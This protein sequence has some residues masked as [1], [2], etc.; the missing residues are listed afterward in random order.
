MPHG[1]PSF[2]PE[3]TFYRR[4]WDEKSNAPALPVIPSKIVDGIV[5]RRGIVY[6]LMNASQFFGLNLIVQWEFKS[7]LFRPSLQALST[8]MAVQFLKF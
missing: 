5:T 4:N 3:A 1:G 8:A 7:P 6:V 2:Y